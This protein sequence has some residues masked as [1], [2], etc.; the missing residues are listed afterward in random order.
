MW[1]K[2]WQCRGA[3]VPVLKDDD[4][5]QAVG[6]GQ[7]GRLWTAPTTGAALNPVPKTGAMTQAVGVDSDGELWTAPTGGGS[8]ATTGTGDIYANGSDTGVDYDYTY[9]GKVLV[10]RIKG[11]T[12][13]MLSG[14]TL[15]FKGLPAAMEVASTYVLHV[16]DY[17]ANSIYFVPVTFEKVANGDLVATLDKYPYNVTVPST[18]ALSF[19]SAGGTG[20][21]F[22]QYLTGAVITLG[23]N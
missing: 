8:G 23:T 13:P 21:Y 20:N 6:V 16:H 3:I 1:C 9:T 5:T 2:F 19:T 12:S 11:A 15:D 14:N 7:D 17:G 4:M 10:I 22:A 18:G